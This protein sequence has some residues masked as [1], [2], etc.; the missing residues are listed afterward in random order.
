MFFR[1]DRFI[2]N[3]LVARLS[4][5][6]IDELTPPDPDNAFFPPLKRPNEGQKRLIRGN[7]ID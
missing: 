6:L 3:E 5:R 7:Q 4:H 2:L 1:R